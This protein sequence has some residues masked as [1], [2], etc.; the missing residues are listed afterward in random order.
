MVVKILRSVLDIGGELESARFSP[1]GGLKG[2][3]VYDSRVPEIA[4]S[5]GRFQINELVFWSAHTSD[6]AY[7]IS[8]QPSPP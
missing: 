8:M 4:G 6:C 3:V 2:V 1:I 7:P 5:V